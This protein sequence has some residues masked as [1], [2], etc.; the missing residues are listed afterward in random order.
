M[1]EQERLRKM[2]D[3]SNWK[4]W[5]EGKLCGACQHW[6][7]SKDKD[8]ERIIEE[9]MVIG[10]AGYLAGLCT[11]DAPVSQCTAAGTIEG[12]HPSKH[13]EDRCDKWVIDESRAPGA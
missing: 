8:G 5:T 10:R 12:Q 3:E 11:V 9:I 2:E 7:Q 1:S 13:S 6:E 4:R